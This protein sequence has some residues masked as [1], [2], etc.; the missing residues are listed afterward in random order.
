MGQPQ[1]YITVVN[2]PTGEIEAAAEAFWVVAAAEAPNHTSKNDNAANTAHGVAEAVLT[3]LQN[4]Y[5]VVGDEL[6][7]AAQHQS[8]CWW[9][10]RE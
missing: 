7:N 10:E 5:G 9:D 6:A 2:D 1:N 8:I 3:K 4:E